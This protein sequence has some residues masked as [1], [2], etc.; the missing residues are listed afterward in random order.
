[1][2]EN[3]SPQAL[4]DLWKKQIEDGTQAWTKLMGQGQ[5]ADPAIFWR[6]YMDQGLAAW[7]KVFTQGP[8]TPDLIVDD[9]WFLVQ[10][11]SGVLVS[12]LRS[13]DP[14]DRELFLVLEAVSGLTGTR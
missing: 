12:A 14:D 2:V 11:Y 1:M 10:K 4:F 7:S 8:V 9:D 5:T 6:P 3:P 13:P